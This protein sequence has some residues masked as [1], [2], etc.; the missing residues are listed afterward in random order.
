MRPAASFGTEF[1]PERLRGAY[2]QAL[3]TIAVREGEL[4]GSRELG[5]LTKG[6]FCK[7]LAVGAALAFSAGPRLQVRL[8]GRASSIGEGWISSTSKSGRALVEIRSAADLR[9]AQVDED[10]H[11]EP[12]VRHSTTPSLAELLRSLDGADADGS[13]RDFSGRADKVNPSEG[14][15]TPGNIEEPQEYPAFMKVQAPDP[16]YVAEVQERRLRLMA[17][18]RAKREARNRRM[19]RAMP[20]QPSSVQKLYDAVH[21]VAS[22][23]RPEMPPTLPTEQAQADVEKAAEMAFAARA[24][25]RA[26]ED[27]GFMGQRRTSQPERAQPAAFT[28]PSASNS[29]FTGVWHDSAGES[30]VL[31]QRGSIVTERKAKSE[32]DSACGLAMRNELTMFGNIGTLSDEVLRWSDGTS[33]VR[34]SHQADGE[35]SSSSSGVGKHEDVSASSPFASAPARQRR[36]D[37]EQ[38]LPPDLADLVTPG[39]DIPTAEWEEG[40]GARYAN[41]MSSHPFCTQPMAEA[42]LRK[43]AQQDPGQQRLWF[44]QW[45]QENVELTSQ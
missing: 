32:S 14:Y 37:F 11:P 38:R 31:V 33:W 17:Q 8:M 34:Q 35:V 6:D 5:Q 24:A 16:E 42:H 7:V 4:V 15:E 40:S 43:A 23:S 13:Q 22:S 2:V 21:S 28:Q 41:P 44:A 20:E 19:G 25:R 12:P 39:P 26:R 9:A 1:S 45:L 27:P 3:D 29:D 10:A 18:E 30:F 36:V